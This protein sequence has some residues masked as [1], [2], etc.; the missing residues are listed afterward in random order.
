MKKT[1]WIAALLLALVV[2]L[3]GCG[4]GDGNESDDV[5]FSN[6]SPNDDDDNN[7]SDDDDNISDDDDFITDDDD[8][9]DD[10]STVDDDDSVATPY[11]FAI[12][13]PGID[14][15]YELHNLPM[16]RPNTVVKQVSSH[17][18]SGLNEDGFAGDTQLYIDNNNEYVVFDDFGPGCINRMW[19]TT[20]NPNQAGNIRIYV[21]DMVNPIVDRIFSNFFAGQFTPF[22]NPFTVDENISSGGFNNYIPIC[23]RTRGKVT[24]TKAPYFYNITYSKYPAGHTVIDFTGEANYSDLTSQWANLD[25]DPKPSHSEVIRTETGQVTVQG[26]SGAIIYEGEGSG[27][28]WDLFLTLSPTTLDLAESLRLSITFDDHEQPDISAPFATLFNFLNKATPTDT[29]FFGYDGTKFYSRLPMPYWSSVKISVV[30]LTLNTPV[31]VDFRI[32][33][34]IQPYPEDAGYLTAIH[35]EEVP[36]TVGADY[37]FADVDGSGHYI[38]VSYN[39]EG[40]LTGTYMEGDERF[41]PNYRNSPTI[42]G[43]GTEDY[44]NGGWYFIKGPFTLPLY[45]AI[46][47]LIPVGTYSSTRVYRYHVSDLIPAY[48]SSHF[49]IEHDWNNLDSLNRNSSVALFYLRPEELL[50]ITDTL[51]LEDPYERT[52]HNYSYDDAVEGENIQSVYE[53]DHDDIEVFGKSVYI[54]GTSTFTLQIDPDNIGVTLRRRYDQTN[55]QMATVYVNDELCGTWYDAWHNDIQ[56]WAESDF[57]LPPSETENLS[58]ITVRIENL[59]GTIP[60]SEHSYQALSYLPVSAVA[61]E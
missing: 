27:A 38:G 29:L 53:G 13:T 41:Y 2:V 10:D 31:T 52:D 15:L 11:D 32:L 16:L 28:I 8:A 4:G 9:G 3:I 7:S 51:D 54:N 37:T 43:T 61:E 21:N 6:D 25:Q 17:D 48:G 26:T 42:Y 40:P 20:Q 33:R 1:I 45:G 19:F 56:R 36:T 57:P 34:I 58:A 60:W 23:F 22:L 50:K 30:N 24:L 39:M 47:R 59:G 14:A 46:E 12:P 35:H 55:P 18:K 49:G 44:F 5:T